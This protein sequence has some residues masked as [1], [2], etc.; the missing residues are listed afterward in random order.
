MLNNKIVVLGSTNQDLV[1]K[2]SHLPKKGERLPKN[3]T[4]FFDFF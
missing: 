3:G 4:F 1:N 2:S